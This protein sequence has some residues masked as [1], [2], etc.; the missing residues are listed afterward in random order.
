MVLWLGSDAATLGVETVLKFE[1]DALGPAVVEL[2]VDK[3]LKID[4]AVVGEVNELDFEE[5]PVVKSE[6][7]GVYFFV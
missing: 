2:V 1:A 7:V 4:I 5:V 3:H 6:V